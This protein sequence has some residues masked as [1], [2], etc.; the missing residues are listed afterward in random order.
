MR[1]LKDHQSMFKEQSSSRRCCAPHGA[2]SCPTEASSE[3]TTAQFA[4]YTQLLVGRCVAVSVQF[5]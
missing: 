2:A 1:P 5:I 4:H 3:E